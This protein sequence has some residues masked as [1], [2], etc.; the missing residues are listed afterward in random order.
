MSVSIAACCNVYQDASA[1][2]GMLETASSYFD[3][4]FIIHSGP[5]GAYSTDGTIELCEEFGIKPIFDDI[6]KGYGVI[7]SRLIHECG[8]AWAF[9]LDCDERFHPLIPVLKCDGDEEWNPAKGFDRFMD[10]HV[11]DT[12]E[13]SNQGKMLKIVIQNEQWMGIRTIRRHWMDF[14]MKHPSQNW[15]K[16]KDFQLRIVRNDPNISYE[17]NRKMHEHLKDSRTGQ[18]P[19]HAT[20]DEYTGFFHDHYH[21]AFRGPKIH[22]GKKEFNELNYDRLNRGMPMVDKGE[23]GDVAIKAWNKMAYG[24][25]DGPVKTS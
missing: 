13:V 11:T 12:G 23:Y 21:L 17:T 6:S 9:I 18:D 5:N 15:I 24:N 4:I 3:N 20:G 2:R 14:S 8:C 16:N 1:L 10:L 25:E 22:R 7:R 19:V